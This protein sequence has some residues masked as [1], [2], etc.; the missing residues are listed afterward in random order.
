MQVKPVPL[1]LYCHF[2]WC[3]Q[4]CPYCDFN[5]H[6]FDG[7]L[8]ESAYIQRLQHDLLTDLSLVEHRQLSSIFLGGGTP[9]LFSADSIKQLLQ[10]IALQFDGVTEIEITMEANPGTFEQEKFAAYRQAGINRLSLGIQS[11]SDQQLKRLGRIH[12]ANAATQAVQRAKQ[13]GFNNINCDLMYGLP[14][15]TLSQA[16]DDLRQVIALQ[17]THISWYQLTLEPNTVFYKQKPPLPPHDD[18]WQMEQAGKQLLAE[19]GYQQYEISAYAQPGY[20]CQHN[21]NYWTFADYLGIGAGAHGKI[22]SSNP[23]TIKRTQKNKMPRHYLDPNKPCLKNIQPLTS[24][25]IVFEYMLNAL[26]LQQAVNFETFEQ[27]TG[28][29]RQTL[30]TIIDTLQQQALV[31]SDSQQ[32]QLTDLGK[33]FR[34]TVISHFLIP[35]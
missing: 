28:L 31:S 18:I 32:M 16:L 6:T 35:V 9:S 19:H 24:N 12:D 20:A 8:A 29:K 5:S 25:D 14:E 11:F 1:S 27:R 22:S 33:R 3:I 23:F 30:H 26:R 34:D 4:K 7:E 2:P 17:P 15:Q 10:F 21:M 13:A